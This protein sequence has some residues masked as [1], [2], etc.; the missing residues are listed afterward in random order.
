MS[1]NMGILVKS[2][3]NTTDP[4]A[5]AENLDADNST[6]FAKAAHYSTRLIWVN[7]LGCIQILKTYRQD[8]ESNNWRLHLDWHWIS[9]K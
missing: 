2:T 8:V 6:N 1:H 5:F 7:I 9:K 3:N 4:F